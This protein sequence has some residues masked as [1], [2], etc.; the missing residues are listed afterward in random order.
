MEIATMSPNTRTVLASVILAGPSL[1][2]WGAP[3]VP[4]TVGCV[5]AAAVL[6]LREWRR[7]DG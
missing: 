3:I 6:L 7:G 2:L 1:I 5:L 4:V